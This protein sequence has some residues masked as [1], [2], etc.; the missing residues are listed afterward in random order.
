MCIIQVCPLLFLSTVGIIIVSHW[1]MLVWRSIHGQ[2]NQFC[3]WF[4][5]QNV[6]H[7][8][9]KPGVWVKH[10][11]N[12]PT[13]IWLCITYPSVYFM[14]TWQPLRCRCKEDDRFS[15]QLGFMRLKWFVYLFVCL[16]ANY[17]NPQNTFPQKPHIRLDQQVSTY[18]QSLSSTNIEIYF[19]L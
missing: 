17:N 8:P 11:L 18:I 16:I 4:W 1:Q 14:Q 9:H 10:I 12:R 19:I 7:L 13:G 3:F 15:Y 5:F 2:Y 6:K